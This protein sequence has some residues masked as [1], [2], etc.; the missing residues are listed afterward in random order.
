MMIDQIAAIGSNR[1]VL[2]ADGLV[3]QLVI[4]PRELD[5]RCGVQVPGEEMARWVCASELKLDEHGRVRQRGATRPSAAWNDFGVSHAFLA[6]CW[7][8][9][10]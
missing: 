9:G 8:R 7:L 3:G 5:P 10:L 6:T 2:L 4:Y 1:P